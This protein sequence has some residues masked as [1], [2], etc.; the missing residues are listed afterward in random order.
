M[1]SRLAMLKVARAY[2]DECMARAGNSD[3]ADLCAESYLRLDRKI[4]ALEKVS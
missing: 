2:W 3:Y 1:T 4:T